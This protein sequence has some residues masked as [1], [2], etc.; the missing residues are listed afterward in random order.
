MVRSNGEGR[1][2]RALRGGALGG[3]LALATVAADLRAG[4]AP[5]EPDVTETID[6]AG[7]SANDAGDV[8]E[9]IAPDTPGDA[10]TGP[11]AK[12]GSSPAS[13]GESAERLRL[14]GWAR[15]SVEY[16]FYDGGMRGSGADDLLRV[17]RDRVASRTEL[18]IRSN[19]QRGH[20]FEAAVSGSLELGTF[21]QSS[22]SDDL[23]SPGARAKVDGELRELYLGFFWPAFDLRLGQQRVAW[24]RADVF[25]PNDVLNARD[26]RDPFLSEAELRT[27]PTPMARGDFYAGPWT[28]EAVVEPVFVPDRFTLYG[29][30]WA[31]IQPDAPAAARGLF[32]LL[33]RRLDP[34]IQDQLDG[35]LQQTRLPD[36]NGEGVSAAA[37]LGLSAEGVDWDLYYQYGYDGTP[38]VTLDPSLARLLGSTNFARATLADLAP[39]LRALDQGIHPI[40]SE[41]IRRHHV[42]FDVALTAGPFVLRVDAAFESQR[43]FY[44]ASDF[45]SIKSPTMLAVTSAEY[46][47]GDL[48]KTLILEIVYVRLADHLAERLLSYDAPTSLGATA[49]WRWPIF[50][51]LGFSF[52]GIV[53]ALPR[54]YMVQPA[55]ELKLGDFLLRGGALAMNGEAG[56]YGWYLRHDTTAYLQVRYGF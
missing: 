25:S 35:V 55:L 19:Y 39:I 13:S 20:W 56:S 43:V 4:E 8:T 28:F 53:G 48:D 45:T 54:F 17:P 49:L 14:G 16:G 40:D 11:A 2:L 46:Q 24:G 51:D 34:S 30:N 47:T 50:G 36:W 12:P 27:L 3:T 1:R 22:G 33:D 6:A 7:T 15:E 21:V 42:G 32:G 52:R 10:T 9:S 26:L 31:V 37:K 38:F 41:Y 44:R 29:S 5:P 18:L 23:R